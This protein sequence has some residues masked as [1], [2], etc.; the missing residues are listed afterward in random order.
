MVTTGDVRLNSQNQEVQAIVYYGL[1]DE[2]K[3]TT[4]VGNGSCFVEMDTSTVFFY[5]ETNGVW[6]EWGAESNG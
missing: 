1:H 6:L 2:T 3:P 4:A 5:D